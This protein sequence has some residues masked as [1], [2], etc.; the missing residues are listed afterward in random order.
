MDG[1]RVE[2]DS[3]HEGPVSPP[4]PPVIARHLGE[5]RE[6]GV[7]ALVSTHVFS[8]LPPWGLSGHGSALP[9]PQG[10]LP[11]RRTPS[12]PSHRPRI[13]G[14]PETVQL[15]A[16]TTTPHP[17]PRPLPVAKAPSP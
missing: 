2:L 8:V 10:D 4:A 14:S 9:E 15:A 1:T 6:T 3:E 12:L 5:G 11:I 17:T 16:Y 7:Q 13:D